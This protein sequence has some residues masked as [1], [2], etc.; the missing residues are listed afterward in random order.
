M[1]SSLD[2]LLVVLAVI[3]GPFAFVGFWM[4]VCWLLG[5]LSGWG[6]LARRYRTNAPEPF[7][8]DGMLS[9]MLGLVSYRGVL[10]VG[11]AE[12]GFDLRVMMLFRAGHPP[13]RIPWSE[14]RV[15]GESSGF[16]TGRVTR[17]RLGEGGPLLRLPTQVWERSEGMISPS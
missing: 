13:V 15:E 1:G 4:A 6:G 5:T 11:F 8:A 2:T 16:L 17:V 12:D 7:G 3:A 14:I 9:G 10:Q